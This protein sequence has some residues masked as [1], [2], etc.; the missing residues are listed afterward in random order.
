MKNFEEFMHG[1]WT[2]LSHIFVS[3]STHVEYD[4]QTDYSF[5]MEKK[6]LTYY[7]TKLYIL[8]SFKLSDL[9]DFLMNILMPVCGI[10]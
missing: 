7:A 5:S 3:R 4:S 1:E 9:I 2:I 10:L 8:L 6:M